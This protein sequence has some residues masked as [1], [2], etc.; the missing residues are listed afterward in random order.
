MPRAALLHRV[1]AEPLLH[2]AILGTGLFVVHA[3][4]FEHRADRIVVTAAF[5]AALREDHAKHTGQPPTPEEERALVERWVDEEVLYREALALGLD[6]GDVIVR[7]RMLQK[8][9]FVTRDTTPVDEPSDQDLARWIEAHA[10][11]YRA[12]GATSFRHVFLSRD[13]R[14]EALAADAAATLAAIRGGADPA[15]LG[16]PFVQGRAFTRRTPRDVEAIFGPAFAESVARLPAGAWSEPI[17]S[18]YGLHLVLVSER[19][20]A[21]TPPFAEI[22]DRARRDLLDARREE[23]D[24]ATRKRL[25]DKYRVEIEGR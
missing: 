19:T 9:E 16:D 6:R 7:R 3:R 24:R 18:S 4:L 8:M 2:F 20:L 10:D 13:R 22:R 5:I 17:A 1:L 25:R 15:A 21:E 14:G 23:L 12:A 11:R